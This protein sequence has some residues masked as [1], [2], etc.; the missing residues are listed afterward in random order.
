VTTP[1]ASEDPQQK[2]LDEHKKEATKDAKDLANGSLTFDVP[3]LFVDIGDGLPGVVKNALKKDEDEIDLDDDASDKEGMQVDIDDDAKGEQYEGLLRISYN[4]YHLVGGGVWQQSHRLDEVADIVS[5]PLPLIDQRLN[6]NRANYNARSLTIGF[7]G[8][9]VRLPSSSFEEK[10][11]HTSFLGC[12]VLLSGEWGRGMSS[13]K[14][15]AL[16]AEDR[17][18]MMCSLGDNADEGES[19]LEMMGSCE[20]A[21]LVVASRSRYHVAPGPITPVQVDNTTR[22]RHRFVSSLPYRYPATSLKSGEGGHAGRFLAMGSVVTS[23]EAMSL[24]KAFRFIHAV[25]IVPLSANDHCLSAKNLDHLLVDCPYTVDVKEK[26]IDDALAEAAHSCKTKG[27]GLTKV[28][29]GNGGIAD[30]CGGGTESGGGTPAAKKAHVPSGDGICHN[31]SEPQATQCATVLPELTQVDNVGVVKPHLID[32]TSPGSSSEGSSQASL[33]DVDES[34]L[35]LAVQE[36]EINVLLLY[37]I[38]M[39]KHIPAQALVMYN[40]VKKDGTLSRF[41][42]LIIWRFLNEVIEPSEVDKLGKKV[43]LRG[44]MKNI[45]SA[46]LNP[47]ATSSHWSPRG[48]DDSYEL[49]KAYHLLIRGKYQCGKTEITALMVILISFVCKMPLILITNKSGFSSVLKSRLQNCIKK[50]AHSSSQGKEQSTSLSQYAEENLF[51]IREKDDSAVRY[52]DTENGFLKKGCFDGAVLVAGDHHVQVEIARDLIVE[53]GKGK[54]AEDLH[55]IPFVVI[56]DESDH[57]CC[58]KPGNKVAQEIKKLQ[59]MG[60]FQ[61]HVSATLLPILMELEENG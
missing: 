17:R 2:E 32:K 40:K 56:F 6:A 51:C 42:D 50:L 57:V 53:I 52:N 54:G 61:I 43:N 13:S 39:L 26:E 25:C 48:P 30:F 19:S 37:Y 22:L 27:D 29:L 45:V 14:C 60:P 58:R 46:L 3:V 31:V 33:V 23:S 20:V 9:K 10:S 21:E 4:L 49:S 35:A 36:E 28:N 24:G 38:E 18:A 34:L 47:S 7:L 8:S 15:D 55:A 1:L 16:S 41:E 12:D 44:M 5:V 11:K 59:E